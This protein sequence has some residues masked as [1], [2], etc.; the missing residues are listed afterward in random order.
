MAKNYIQEGDVLDHIAAAA[1]GSGDVVLM[2]KRIGVAVADIAS[3]ATGS[4]AVEGVF[5]L[6]KVVTQAP[7]Q[8]ALL[9]WDAAAS[10]ITTTATGNT[11]AGYAAAPGVNGSL[12]VNININH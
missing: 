9:Y 8:G 4:V 3:G 2:G 7:A 10:N 12:T 6:P 11:L 1:I 5:N